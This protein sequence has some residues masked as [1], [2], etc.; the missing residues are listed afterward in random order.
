VDSRILKNNQTNFSLEVEQHTHL[1]YLLY[2]FPSKHPQEIL[3]ICA[4]YVAQEITHVHQHPTAQFIVCH[5]HLILHIISKQFEM[6]NVDIYWVYAI[7]DNGQEISLEYQ[8][9]INIF[10]LV[11]G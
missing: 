10:H 4:E 7:I 2:R 8:F 1:Q 5:I 9:E 3:L 11:I 6:I